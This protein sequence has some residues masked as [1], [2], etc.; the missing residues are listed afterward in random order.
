MAR[1]FSHWLKFEESLAQW[2]GLFESPGL[3]FKSGRQAIPGFPSSGFRAD[4]LL[5]DGKVLLALE[6][7][8]KQTHPDT[9][10]GKYWLLT[11]H[12]PY[13]K[14]ILFHVYTP[15]YNS[16]GWRKTLGEFYAS[17]ME[18]E[19][20]FEY[21]LLDMRNVI[22]IQHAF[23]EVTQKLEERINVEFGKKAILVSP[24]SKRS[25]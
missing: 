21:H 2:M 18:K 25:P 13:E 3:A 6:V 16:Y 20:P 9:N 24:I 1:D 4:G 15:A 22:D 10:V 8:V 23:G 7:E 5:T 12:Q 19:I 11:Q 17:K 14:V